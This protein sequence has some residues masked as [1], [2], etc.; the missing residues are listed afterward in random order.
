[1]PT[2]S[3]AGH[4]Q[5]IFQAFCTLAWLGLYIAQTYVEPEPGLSRLLN[6]VEVVSLIIFFIFVIDYIFGLLMAEDRLSHVVSINSF[7]D[8]ISITPVIIPFFLSQESQEEDLVRILMV[9]RALRIVRFQPLLYFLDS[10]TN[11][12][13]LLAWLT[14]YCRFAA[15]HL[16]AHRQLCR[17]DFHFCLDRERHPEVLRVHGRARATG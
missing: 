3:N 16:C 11:P 1:M 13:A 9:I 12:C 10:G 14:L 17:A 15:R 2:Q 8:I 5:L 6:P 4:Y 7:L